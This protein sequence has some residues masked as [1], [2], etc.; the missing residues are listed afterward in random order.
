[1]LTD[2]EL[3]SLRDDAALALPDT[4]VIQTRTFTSDGGGGGDY[5]WT[6]AGTLACRRAPLTATTDAEGVTGG[7]ISADADSL[8]TLPYDAAVTT[9]SRFIYSG[10][11]F[12]VEA[13]RERSWN[14]TTRVEASK[15]V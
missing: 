8:F 14:T 1:M 2:D 11:T 12:N 5:P 3:A 6:N 13:I 15:E 7:R 9:D 4:V 10:G